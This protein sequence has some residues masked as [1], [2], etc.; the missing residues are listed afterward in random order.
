M[1][2]RAFRVVRRI[3][4]TS[5]FAGRAATHC[6]HP[7]TP[8]KTSRRVAVNPH[9]SNSNHSPAAGHR[10]IGNPQ[11]LPSPT[12]TAAPFPGASIKRSLEKIRIR[13]LTGCVPCVFFRRDQSRH[14][15]QTQGRR[16]GAG[17]CPGGAPSIQTLPARWTCHRTAPEE[18]LSARYVEKHLPPSWMALATLK[19]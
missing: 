9:S 3:Q 1:R 4:E 14:H 10:W 17:E 16:L 5:S 7:T 19:P 18:G 13:D 15:L 12:S 11:Q 6:Q 2:R 8:N